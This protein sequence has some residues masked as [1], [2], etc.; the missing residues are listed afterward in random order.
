MALAEKRCTSTA[1]N[2]QFDSYDSSVSIASCFTFYM[3]SMTRAG[4]GSSCTI[5][6]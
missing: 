6:I 3:R 5:Q 1:E 4:L 2:A